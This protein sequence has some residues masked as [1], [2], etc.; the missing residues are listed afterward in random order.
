[1]FICAYLLEVPHDLLASGAS[2]GECVV[3]V[4]ETLDDL[5]THL[6]THGLNFRS[7]CIQS[8]IRIG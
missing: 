5:K 8:F 4:C 2:S 6:H 1:M 7:M 3:I